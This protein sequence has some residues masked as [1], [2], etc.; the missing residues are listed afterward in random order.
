MIAVIAKTFD[1]LERIDATNG[2]PLMLKEIVEQT[3]I[4]Q[5]TCA[6]IIQNLVDLGYV[7][8]FGP[9]QGYVIGPMSKALGNEQSWWVR[10]RPVAEP[11]ITQLA[12]QT[13]EHALLAVLQ[14]T[15]RHIV[16]SHSANP[17]ISVRSGESFDDDLYTTVT[18]RMLLAHAPARDVDSYVK[19]YGMPGKAWDN[20]RSRRQLDDAIAAIRQNMHEHL[21]VV[22]PV[23]TIM[24][25]PV[26]RDQQ[27]I[28]AIGIA[29]PSS[30]FDDRQ[31]KQAL[32]AAKQSAENLAD[33]LK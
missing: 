9:R 7:S 15:R 23:L 13:G 21:I 32:K 3:G 4:N 16:C 18:G 11:D 6:R 2:K 25:V 22:G 1:I 26:I 17:L 28:A 19:K 27:H 12:N 14:R 33:K 31:Q 30:T 8:K 24:A 29:A 10:W 20:I 5:P